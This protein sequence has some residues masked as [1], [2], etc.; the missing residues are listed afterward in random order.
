MCGTDIT[1]DHDNVLNH[2]VRDCVI[3]G[4]SVIS[5]D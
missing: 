3:I 2:L 1:L 4:S 5:A